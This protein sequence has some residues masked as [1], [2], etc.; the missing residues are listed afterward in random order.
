MATK[1]I[2]GNTATAVSSKPSKFES[3]HFKHWQAKLKIFLT[4]KKVVN[5]KIVFTSYGNAKIVESDASDLNSRK[6]SLYGKRMTI[7]ANIIFWIVLLVV[8]M[9]IIVTARMQNKYGKLCKRSMAS[10]KS[11]QRNML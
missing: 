7:S 10:R 4:L 5:A 11:K 3:F 9:I 1:E 2:I 6:K 8:C